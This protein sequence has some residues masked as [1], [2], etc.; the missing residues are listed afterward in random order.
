KSTTN[1]I[2]SKSTTTKVNK[3]SLINFTVPNK[4]YI[5]GTKTYYANNI[6]TQKNP[7]IPNLLSTDKCGSKS[8]GVYI[9]KNNKCCSNMVIVVQV[10]LIVVQDA[11]QIMENVGNP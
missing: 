4:T 8:D 6:T 3:V 7:S 5:V 2:K 1:G 11:N 9:C 10:M